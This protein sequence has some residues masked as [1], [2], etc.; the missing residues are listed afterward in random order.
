MFQAPPS[1]A[2]LQ[3][4]LLELNSDVISRNLM[5]MTE[6][7]YEPVVKA[8]RMMTEQQL[9]SVQE[10]SVS[11]KVKKNLK[12]ILIKNAQHNGRLSNNSST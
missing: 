6:V 1:E 9:R 7:P 3:R 8:V 2:L 5:K 4:C 10:R 12:E 11:I